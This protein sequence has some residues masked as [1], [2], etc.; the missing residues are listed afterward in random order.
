MAL[1]VFFLSYVYFISL[2]NI[3]QALASAFILIAIR[4]LIEDKVWKYIFFCIVAG[5][6]KEDK[7]IC[8]VA[9]DWHSNWNGTY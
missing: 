5:L 4:C 7:Y 9:D 2:N 3:R 8:M 1:V 6:D